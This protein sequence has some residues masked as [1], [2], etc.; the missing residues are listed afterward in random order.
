MLHPNLMMLEETLF[1]VGCL[2]TIEARN[3][4]LVVCNNFALDGI[5]SGVQPTPLGVTVCC[6][7]FSASDVDV[8]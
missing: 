2:V 7:L 6:K 1:G 4:S 5:L 3:H 8:H